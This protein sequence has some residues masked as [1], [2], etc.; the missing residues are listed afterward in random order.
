MGDSIDKK[1]LLKLLK[2]SLLYRLMDN[3]DD[4]ISM[5]ELTH[6]EVS[7]RA[8]KTNNW[9]NDAYNNNEDIYIS[10]FISVLSVIDQQYKLKDYKLMD[11]FTEKILSISSLISRV[12]D[13]EDDYVKQLIIEEKKLFLDIL[14]D[15]ASMEYRNKLTDK[16]KEIM[17]QVRSLIVS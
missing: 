13:E 8:G 14:G 11:I 3:I 10:N 17:K 16:E 1:V 5:A 9:F 4:L 7:N 12:H 15:L 6:R 2:K